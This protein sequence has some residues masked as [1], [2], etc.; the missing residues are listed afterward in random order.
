V[1]GVDVPEGEIHAPTRGGRIW[2][3][4]VALGNL[5]VEKQGGMTCDGGKLTKETRSNFEKNISKNP[6]SFE[7]ARGTA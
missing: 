2:L 1:H 4:E 6:T 5:E 3:E 7:E